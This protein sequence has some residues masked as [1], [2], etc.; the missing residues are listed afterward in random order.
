MASGS[1]SRKPDTSTS[2]TTTNGTPIAGAPSVAAVMTDIGSSRSGNPG[3]D[4][5]IATFTGIPAITRC[6]LL[7]RRPRS[8]GSRLFRNG[9][10]IASGAEVHVAVGA[11]HAL[12]PHVLH[13][14]QVGVEV[15]RRH[16]HVG[17]ERLIV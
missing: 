13:S 11:A 6:L 15:V 4:G 10:E 9:W 5:A 12:H 1:P 3:E 16:D 2:D 17:G 8:I 7:V 14:G